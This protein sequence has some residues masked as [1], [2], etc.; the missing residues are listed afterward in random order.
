MDRRAEAKILARDDDPC[1]LRLLR[2]RLGK[3][4]Y[5]RVTAC[6]SG[7]T[8][9]EWIDGCNAAPQPILFDLNMPDMDGADFVHHLAVNGE[10][11]NHC[12]PEVEVASGPLKG[13]A[14]LVRWNHP[15]AGMV[16]PDQ[17]INVAE[18]HGLN[19]ALTLTVLRSREF[20]ALS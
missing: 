12:Q 3:L 2:T 16:F 11:V 20:A 17:F 7:D 13:M 15:H 5:H 9:L 19:D 8:A 4:G 14:S 6:T 18:D 10:P 1:M